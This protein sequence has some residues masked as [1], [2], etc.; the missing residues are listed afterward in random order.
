MK[1]VGKNDALLMAFLC[2]YVKNQNSD[3]VSCAPWIEA[4]GV[5][6]LRLNSEM[7]LLR[8]IPHLALDDGAGPL[9]C[10]V[11]LVAG[12]VITWPYQLARAFYRPQDNLSTF[13]GGSLLHHFKNAGI[14]WQ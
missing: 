11:L 9:L 2:S 6:P 10:S 7:L 14:S 1:G 12:L 5:L 8:E 3:E 13:L 4:T